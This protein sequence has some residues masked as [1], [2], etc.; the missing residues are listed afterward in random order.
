MDALGL[1]VLDDRIFLS[2]VVNDGMEKGI[3]TRDRADEIIRISVAMSNKYVL[4]KEVDFRSVERL[5]KVQETILKLMG[6]GLE[7][8]S[9]RDMDEAIRI[10]M[11]ESPVDLF[12]LAYTRIEKLRHA[13]RL[14]LE[15][16]R[17]EI[18]VRQDEYECLD[19]LTCQRLSEMSIFSDTELDTIRSMKLEDA[20]F[21]N[22]SILE[23]YESQLERFRFILRLKQILPFGLLNRSPAVRAEAIAEADSIREALVNTLIISGHV[24]SED[25]VTVSLQ[26]VRHFL[27]TLDVS[28]A[29][30]EFPELY[31]NVV[32][33]LIQ[34]LG[35][36]LEETEA[37]QLT[38][39]IV[40]MAQGFLET[41]ISEWDTLNSSSETTF[42][43]RWARLVFL[44]DILDPVSR[45]LTSEGTIDQFDMDM[46][47]EHLGGRPEDEALQLARTLPWS[48]FVPDQI[49]R[50]FH[51]FQDI[52]CALG[53]T[54]EL[55]GFA[56][57]DLV[58]LLEVLTPEA[59]TELMP[60]LTTA[61]AK[62]Q[63]TLE[64]LEV[65]AALPHEEVPLLLQAAGLPSDYEFNRIAS[66]FR[67]GTSL[68]RKTILYCCWGKE[69][70][71]DLVVEVWASAPDFLMRFLKGLKPSDIGPFFAAAAGTE[72]PRV[73]TGKDGGTL[74]FRSGDLN[75]IFQSLPK[76]KKAAVVDYF[77]KNG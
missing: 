64:D 69:V 27:R 30:E 13:W 53:T 15:D 1:V 66:E 52:Q 62:G 39:E 72:T 61:A 3:F 5:A 20:L 40:R 25:P 76:T 49:I 37:E 9:G 11:E 58:D 19:E 50:I 34:E 41:I 43:K 42:F 18:L 36:G 67:D 29:S 32:V 60:K 44:S 77:V 74:K 55:T 22:L 14:L 33:D 6:V 68:T 38:Q 45:I 56:A 8:R 12:R 23:Y 57:A 75:E 46:L 7:L 51:D 28:G 31:E 47:V 48:R 17:V 71:P 16:H 24:E 4:H 2:K 65:I 54:L 26:D 35:E 63:L 59:F 70:F 73:E 21:S 10:L